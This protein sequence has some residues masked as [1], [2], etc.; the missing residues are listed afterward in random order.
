MRKKTGESW[1]L[2]ATAMLNGVISK[3]SHSDISAK[4]VR[5]RVSLAYGEERKEQLVKSL[6]GQEH[7]WMFVSRPHGQSRQM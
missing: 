6:L 3:G 5:E 7:V 1:E 2:K 4:E